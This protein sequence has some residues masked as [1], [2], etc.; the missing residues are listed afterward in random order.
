MSSK[1][2][3]VLQEL[4][5]R[6]NGKLSR[7]EVYDAN[8]CT[9]RSVPDKP[10]ELVTVSGEPFHQRLRCTYRGRKIKVLENRTYTNGIVTGTFASSPFSVNTKQRVGFQSEYASTLAVAGV[11]YP[12]F[13]EDGR[14]SQSQEDLLGGAELASLVEQSNLR[15]GEMLYFTKN[16]IGFYLMQPTTDH[17]SGVIDRVIDLAERVEIAEEKLNL[18]LLPVQF[19]PLIPLIERWAFPDD[20]ERNDLLDVASKSALR[21]LIDEVDPFLEVIDAYLDSFREGTP[22][23]Q[24]TA[25]A[26]LAECALEAKQHLGDP[27]PKNCITG[28]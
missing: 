13:T 15:E 7:C 26:R 5:K 2:T 24:A 22:S 19:Y 1:P 21:A 16:E 27:K 9:Y 17:V 12:V 18:K 6:F 11:Q 23:E 28:N 25:L 3:R 8:V 14:L 20:S 4:A 10:W